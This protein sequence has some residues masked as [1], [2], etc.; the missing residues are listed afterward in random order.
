LRLVDLAAT[1]VAEVLGAIVGVVIA[2]LMFSLPAI[3]MSTH[4][5]SGPNLG[6]ARWWRPSASC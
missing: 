3:G 4:V 6:S 1:I 2:N 5:R